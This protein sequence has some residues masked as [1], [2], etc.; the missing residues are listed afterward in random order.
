MTWKQVCKP[1]KERGEGIRDC[2]KWNKATIR[3][4]VWDVARKA[5][6]LWVKWINN[7]Y[8]KNQDWKSHVP[9][10]DACWSLK[11]IY[12]VRD[13]FAHMLILG[14]IGRTTIRRCRQ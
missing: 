2:D 11:K 1:K 6:S 3:K 12:K 13:L 5:Y 4:I 10:V 7:T 9:P 8:L 14:M